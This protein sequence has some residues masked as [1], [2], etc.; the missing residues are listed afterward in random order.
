MDL[1]DPAGFLKV[2]QERM[3]QGGLDPR[4]LQADHLC[5]RTESLQRYE[6]LREMMR[7]RN[8]LLGEQV[9][10]GRPIATFRLARAYPLLP[11][12]IS[13]VE[14]AAPKAGSPY[15]EGWEHAEFVV[16]EDL[17]AFARRHSRLDWDLGG[18]DKPHGA[19]LRLRFGD[20]SVKFRRIPLAQ[21]IALERLSVGGGRAEA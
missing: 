18:A 17:R 19:E 11:G 15:A 13:I 4:H 6:A 14:L 20:C 9:I 3:R 8:E 2:L 10:N 7:E 21:A 1:E 16:H 12:A 5:Y